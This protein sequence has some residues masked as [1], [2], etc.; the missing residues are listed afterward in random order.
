MMSYLPETLDEKCIKYIFENSQRQME[1]KR[2]DNELTKLRKQI[3]ANRERIKLEKEL[4]SEANETFK[5]E[6]NYKYYPQKKVDKI[7]SILE[8]VNSKNEINLMENYSVENK[9]IENPNPTPDLD[10]DLSQSKQLQNKVLFHITEPSKNT[11]INRMI[12]KPKKYIYPVARNYNFSTMKE[13]ISNVIDKHQIDPLTKGLMDKVTSLE[14]CKEK[15]LV[16]INEYKDKELERITKEFL[17]NDYSKRFN[18]NIED[19]TRAI[20]GTAKVNIELKKI[21]NNEKKAKENV[22]RL[23]FFN[24]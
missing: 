15:I 16:N 9:V 21:Y 14:N 4:E 17:F 18:A 3:A 19:V 6:I 12:K 23:E 2:I 5:T 8:S 20:V 22:K 13:I 7:K 1:L 24:K 10:F 11:R